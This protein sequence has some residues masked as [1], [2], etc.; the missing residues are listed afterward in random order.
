[1][2][3][4]RIRTVLPSLISESQSAFVPG[5]LISNNII[6]VAYETHHS[7][8]NK[9]AG[10]KGLTSIKLDMSKTFDRVEWCFV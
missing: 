8:K 7:L 9:S 5:R 2:V 1:M 3:S 6:L 10:S 4:N